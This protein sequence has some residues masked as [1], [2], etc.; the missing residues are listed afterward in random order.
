MLYL[1]HILHYVSMISIIK[2]IASIFLLSYFEKT[3]LLSNIIFSFETGWYGIIF[4]RQGIYQEG[5]FRFKII[6]PENYPDGDCPVIYIFKYQNN[7][8][9]LLHSI[10]VFNSHYISFFEPFF[11]REF[12]LTMRFF[13]LLSSLNLL[14][15]LMFVEDH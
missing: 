11:Y 14:L 12:F 10:L 6:I 5:I 3:T 7:Q 9:T 8:M 1:L 2:W 4:V 13:I 15:N